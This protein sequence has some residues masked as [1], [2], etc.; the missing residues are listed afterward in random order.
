M[1]EEMATGAIKNQESDVGRLVEQFPLLWQSPHEAVQIFCELLRD[2]LN[3]RSAHGLDAQTLRHYYRKLFLA[4]GTLSPLGVYGYASRLAPALLSL[5]EAGSDVKL[6]DAGCGYGTEALLFALSG[7]DVT[8]VELVPER[9]ELARSRISFYQNHVSTPLSIRFIN[10][11]IMRYLERTGPFD[12]IWALEATSHIHPLEDF[13]PLARKCLSPNGLLITSDPNALNLIAFYR[14]CRIRG[15]PRYTL[16]I[17]AQDP[18]SGAPVCEA[19]ERIFP[20]P[21]YTRRL[22][23]AGFKVTQVAMSGFLG[24]S[25]VPLALHTNRLVFILL[26]SLQRMLRALPILRLMGANYTVVAQKG[27]GSVESGD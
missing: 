11:N 2:E 4:D 25:F 9:V 19:V 21:N 17:K 15:A 12:I 7:A 23:K 27:Y 22:S 10:A 3:Y 1:R 26:S 8:G 14:A 20:V 16:R 24:S 5:E 18:D 13:L 6:L